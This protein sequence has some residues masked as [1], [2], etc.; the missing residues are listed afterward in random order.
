MTSQSNK[1]KFES[2]ILWN[3]ELQNL[4][5][6]DDSEYGLVRYNK[7]YSSRAFSSL[8]KDS[9]TL[10]KFTNE[11]KEKINEKPLKYSNWNSK[12][13]SS[14]TSYPPTV[15]QFRSNPLFLESTELEEA[16][17]SFVDNLK[18][19]SPIYYRSPSIN[20]P[21]SIA[22]RI[23]A[24]E[25]RPIPPVRRQVKGCFSRVK[26]ILGFED[27]IDGYYNKQDELLQSYYDMDDINAHGGK[28]D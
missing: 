6:F 17:T 11:V 14:K 12:K 19:G 1:R 18:E 13:F 5:R 25:F 15:T 10:R 21:S 28:N 9:K 26:K 16:S 20:I 27:P 2:S 24:S 22:W 7:P 3:H 8:S 4:P 23:K